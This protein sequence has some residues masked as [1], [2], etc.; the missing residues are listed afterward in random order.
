MTGKVR[1][2][3]GKSDASG[4]MVETADVDVRGVGLA[5]AGIAALVVVGA[6]AAAAFLWTQGSIREPPA[7]MPQ[8]AAPAPALQT[9]ERNDRQAIEA[10]ARARLAGRDGGVPIGLAIRRTAALGWD[11]PR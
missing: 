9:N 1:T 6:L 10:R 2:Q 4:R 3:R 5:I 11:A 7:L 8:T